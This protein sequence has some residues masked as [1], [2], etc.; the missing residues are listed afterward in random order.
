[1]VQR[2]NF[3]ATTSDRPG[4]RQQNADNT[5]ARADFQAEAVRRLLHERGAVH[6][7]PR[8]PSTC[9]GRL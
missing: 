5:L 8:P 7:P 2:D 1:M 4:L 6:S 3:G 9:K